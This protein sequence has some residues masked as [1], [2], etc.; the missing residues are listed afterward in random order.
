[1]LIAYGAKTSPADENGFTALHLA[2]SEAQGHVK[3]LDLLSRNEDINSIH[4]DGKSL[5]HLSIEEGGDMKT[6][7]WLVD[8]GVNIH[9]TDRDGCSLIHSAARYGRTDVVE[10]LIEHHPIDEIIN[11][12]DNNGNTPLHYS[13]NGG[14]RKNMSQIIKKLVSFVNLS[15]F[16]LV[17]VITILPKFFLVMDPMLMS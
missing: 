13:V 14:E 7:K 15:F 9:A 12:Q 6:F 8:K 3:I 16:S 4:K 1:M 2:V 17:K 11:K 10:W 5:L